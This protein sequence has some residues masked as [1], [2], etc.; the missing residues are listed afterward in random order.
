MRSS[1][2]KNHSAIHNQKDRDFLNQDTQK[3]YHH[4]HQE[5]SY[6][7]KDFVFDRQGNL[8]EHDNII[9]YEKKAYEI[10]YKDSFAEQ[11]SQYAKNRQYK[12]MKSDIS[13]WYQNDKKGFRETIFQ[14]GSDESRACW[15]ENGKEMTPEEQALALKDC[16]QKLNIWKR[17]TFPNYKPICVSIHMDE[18]SVHAHQTE[19]I[20]AHDKND[21]LTPNMNKGFEEMGINRP[22]LN[23]KQSKTNNPLV[24]YTELCRDKWEEIVLDY[25]IDIQKSEKGKGQAHLDSLVFWSEIKQ[26][27]LDEKIE[28]LKVY[29]DLLKDLK[30]LVKT[31]DYIGRAEEIKPFFKSLK[32][33][34]INTYQSLKNAP[35]D[36]QDKYNSMKVFIELPDKVEA[37]NQVMDDIELD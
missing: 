25:G 31:K 8:I 30:V 35:Q 9:A 14:I 36:I 32:D 7:N 34:I 26:K 33:E 23:K 4:I 17:E 3:T 20:F 15:K 1:G 27:E 28:Q 13:E 37:I 2:S 12:K 16:I 11:N 22:N 5:L 18:L 21:N 24:A 6:L 19:T 29:D 10:L